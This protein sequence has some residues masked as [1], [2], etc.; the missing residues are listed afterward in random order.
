MF[1]AA[2]DLSSDT[3]VPSNNDGCLD[4]TA[5]L[6]SLANLDC[7]ASDAQ[8]I[9]R[10]AGL[11]RLKAGCAAAQARMTATFIDSQAADGAARKHRPDGIRR[12]IAGQVGLARRDSPQAGRRHV[13]VATALVADMPHTLAALTRGELSE[14]RARIV[15]EQLACLTP[16]GRREA[17][18]L[19]APDLPGM[20]DRS[21]ETRAA[22]V[23][24]RLDPEAVMAKVRG[25]V[26]DRHVSL[27]P[28]PET[29]TRL[30]ALLPVALGV[31]VYAALG[32]AAD[33]TTASPGGDPRSRGQL[34]A[35]ALVSAVTGRTVTG[36][37]A[38]GVPHYAPTP[39]AAT[40][41]D[42]TTT[43]DATQGDDTADRDSAA[44]D[45]RT[46]RAGATTQGDDAADQDTADQ[47]TAAATEQH[48]ADACDTTAAAA[49]LGAVPAGPANDCAPSASDAV[50]AATGTAA[51]AT[52]TAGRASTA[53][54]APST[55]TAAAVARCTGGCGISINLVMTDRTLLDGD[56]E[57]AH[58]TGFGPIPAALA[59]ALVIGAADTTTCTFIRRLYTD[60]VTGRLD[61]MDTTRRLFPA[62]AQRFLLAR[63]QT[64]RTPWC[65]AP[66]RQYDHLQPHA[67]GGPTTIIN[68][69]GACQACNLTKESPRWFTR[70]DDGTIHLTAPTGHTY[71]STPPPPPRSKPWADIS[72]TEHRLAKMLLWTA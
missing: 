12:S 33:S 6:Q 36:C 13:G 63:D 34:M 41:D 22:A 17:D 45:D 40:D 18:Q 16:A 67:D 58:L 43:A 11:E 10:I 62:S 47:D 57:P 21:A 27:R 35:D 9:D 15:V 59:R 48:A 55:G 66:I 70:S 71:A 39:A 20:G 32:R 42:R 51:A 65:D 64:C 68:G 2:D 56:D 23:A 29:M 4:L 54:T 30:S 1:T 60:P 53:P 8:L 3:A 28:A 7:N 14:R 26:K 37:D 46:P 52:S 38:Y 31:A 69:R 72:H 19:L 44:A 61:A 24:Y 49:D 50:A 5:L 25:A